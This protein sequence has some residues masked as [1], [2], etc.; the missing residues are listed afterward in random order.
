M[1]TTLV[2]VGAI[3]QLSGSTEYRVGPMLLAITRSAASGADLVSLARPHLEALAQTTGEATGL[4]IL[5]GRGCYYLDQVE[6]TNAVRIRN[7][8]GERVPLHLVPSGLVLIAGTT[9]AVIDAYLPTQW[10]ATLH[11]V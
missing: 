2:E 9:P 4:A 5:D 10:P 3:E 1:L 7:W 8:V 6:S 11:T